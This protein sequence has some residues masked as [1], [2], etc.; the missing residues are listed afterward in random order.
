MDIKGMLKVNIINL[1]L[2]GLIGLVYYLFNSIFEFSFGLT[3]VV[4]GLLGLAWIVYTLY[5]NYTMLNVNVN[6]DHDIDSKNY[7]KDV[8]SKLYAAGKRNYFMEERNR[9]ARAY[10][11]VVSRKAYLEKKGRERRVYELYE[12]TE[13]Q[14]LRNII[15]STEYISTYDYISGRDNGYLTKMCYDSELLVDKFNKLMELSVSY[16][17]TTLGY[18]TK[19]LDD[20]IESLE[21]MRESGKGRLRG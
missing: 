17:D 15:D 21:K 1:V 6:R 4:T 9:L 13:G 2:L 5:S 20:M 11:S 12:L 7:A 8:L 19:E 18:D 16:D 14:I 10:E 3:A